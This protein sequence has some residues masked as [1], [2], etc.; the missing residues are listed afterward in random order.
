M[1]P[2]PKDMDF[3]PYAG[4]WVAVIHGRIVAQ[5]GTPH[6]ATRAAQLSRPKE[7]SQVF[8]VPMQNALIFHPIL[9]RIRQALP[10]DA[11]VFLVG[12][13]VRDSILARPVHDFDFVFSGDALRL[14]RKV[15]DAVNGAFFPLDE[16][17]FTGRVIT[18]GEGDDRLVLDFAAM[19]GSDLE[20]DLKDRDF[21]VNAIAVDI[22]RPQEILDPLGGMTDLWHKTLRACSND[23]FVQDPLRIL[24]GI[25]LAARLGYRIHT[26][27]RERMREAV[28]SLTQISPE[29]LRDEILRILGGPQTHT[30]VR[31]LDMLGVLPHV[32]PELPDLKGVSQS[33]PHIQPVWEHTLDTLKHLSLLLELFISRHDPDN[34][35]GLVLGVGQ[36]RLGRYRQQLREHLKK[37]IVADRDLRSLLFFAALYHDIA[38]PLTRQV[39]SSGRIRFFDHD[40]VGSDMLGARAEALHLSKREIDR[41]KLIVRHHMRPAH[42]AREDRIPSRRAVYRFFRDT[43]EAGIDICLLSLADIL[44]AYGNTLPQ[45]RWARQLDVVRLLMDAWWEQPEKQV[46]PPAVLTGKD[47][48]EEFGLKPGPKIGQLLESVREAQA[49]GQVAS[50]QDALALIE[51]L[52]NTEA[53]PPPV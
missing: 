19:R 3:S 53:N 39:E 12:G 49:I 22:S 30:A 23:A 16:T 46:R 14:A 41:L 21:T 26:G 15:A 6:Q 29:R 10:A 52:I 9:D 38:K 11:E 25:R 7:I 44:A 40:Q 4:R 8:Y 31:A 18:T 34:P 43:G 2:L 5:G 17:R 50:R 1:D 35:L 36:I 48:I 42:L 51:S 32:L 27:T 20:A 37:E 33:P 24:R 47:L 45:E 13:A 28:P